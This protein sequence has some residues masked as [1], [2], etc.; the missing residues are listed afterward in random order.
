MVSAIP[1][2]EKI[3][4]VALDLSEN[5]PEYLLDSARSR[6]AMRQ[7]SVAFDDNLSNGIDWA[8]IRLLKNTVSDSLSYCLDHPITVNGMAVHI[9]GITHSSDHSSEHVAKAIEKISP[10]KIFLESCCDRTAARMCVQMPLVNK[11]NANWE[12]LTDCVDFGGSGPSLSELAKHGLLDAENMDVSQFMTASGSISGSPELTVLQHYP[13]VESI[14]ILESIKIVQNAS[15]DTC[16]YT[17]RRAGDISEGVLRQIVDEEGIIS[18]YFRLMYGDKFPDNVKP[19]ILYRLIES[20]KRSGPFADFLLREL[21]RIYRSKQYWCRIFLR[22]IYMS[23]RI[24]HRLTTAQGPVLVVVGGAHVFGIR[25]LL[26]TSQIDMQTHTALA[27]CCLLDNAKQLCE[28][29]RDVLGIESFSLNIPKNISNS[30]EAALR[31]AACILNHPRIAYW[32]GEEWQVIN[33]DPSLTANVTNIGQVDLAV[34]L[35]EGKIDPY[36]IA[37]RTNAH[38]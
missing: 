18:E 29:W 16:G 17:C 7:L 10:C 25:D 31:I 32:V 36:S 11:Y 28:A 21:H 3:P 15:I 35:L 2:C 26:T 34:A 5:A 6:H 33:S 20:Q 1:L 37:R 8:K 22:D 14:D 9:L 30:N 38:T 19:S 4:R 12:L 13:N 23:W 24:R 27:L